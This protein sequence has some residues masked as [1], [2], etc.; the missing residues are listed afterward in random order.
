MVTHASR[1]HSQI[2]ITNGTLTIGYTSHLT[3]AILTIADAAV[4]CNADYLNNAYGNRT[5]NYLFSVPPAI[6]GID[7]PYTYYNGP[8]PAVL[9]STVAL[10]LQTYITSFAED[11]N[12]NERGVPMFGMVGNSSR[13]LNLNITSIAEIRGYDENNE[14]CAWWQKALYY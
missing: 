14:R 7:V 3:R 6:H 2:L 4:N 13:I 1:S 5:Y 10:A 9:S 12:P 11:G 8:N